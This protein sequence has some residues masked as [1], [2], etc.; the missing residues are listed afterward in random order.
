MEEED[1][2]VVKKVKVDSQSHKYDKML[3]DYFRLDVNLDK[4][5]IEWSTV[6]PYF[7]MAAEEFYGIRILAQ[8]PVENIFSFICS[9]NNNISRITN[10]VNTMCDLY[11]PKIAEIDGKPY[12]AFPKVEDLAG[13]GVEKALREAGFG[14]RAGYIHKSAKKILDLGGDEWINELKK[15][16]YT[17]AKKN[18]MRLTGV[19]AKVA[20]CIC[21]MSLDHLEAI[22][23]D[24]HIYQI[25]KRC[26][27]KH[28]GKQK[29]VTE[30]IY[31]EIGDHF[32]KLYGPYAGWAHTVSN[33][34]NSVTIL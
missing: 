22:P 13:D 3:R 1:E 5:Y 25:A 9:S 4:Y 27:L 16:D 17:D 20:D 15:M 26:Y 18:L 30:K 11:G 28:L 6:D 19:G 31:N 21:L 2:P 8:D 33:N 23:V 12:H 32:R 29:T 24:T 10:M 34:N 14:Y 7:E